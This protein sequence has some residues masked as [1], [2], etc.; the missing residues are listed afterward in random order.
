MAFVKFED[1]TD[2]IEGVIFPKLFK[3]IGQLV[4]PGACVLVKAI[5]S[6]RNG[7][8]SLSIENLKLL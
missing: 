5:V 2:A 4:V 6:G 3:E 1:K 8:T 7:E